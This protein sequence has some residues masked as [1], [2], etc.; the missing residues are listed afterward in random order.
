MKKSVKKVLAAVLAL[1]LIALGFS[2]CGGKEGGDSKKASGD[3]YA[4]NNTE[5]FIGTTGPLTG[6][7]ASYGNSV[8]NGA[9][10]AIEEI[11]AAGGLNGVKFKF[12]MKDDKATAQDA[13]TGYNSA[14]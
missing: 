3:N 4:A 13:T 11:N 9:T 6:D 14:L 7:N 8:K 5:Y 10:I 1:A 12:D 2:A